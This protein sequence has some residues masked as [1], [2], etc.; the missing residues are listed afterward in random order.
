MFSTNIFILTLNQTVASFDSTGMIEE[1]RREWLH[2]D[3]LTSHNIGS[4]GFTDS[5]M[6]LGINENLVLHLRVW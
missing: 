6:F 1:E 2:N 4:E 5:L 3:C